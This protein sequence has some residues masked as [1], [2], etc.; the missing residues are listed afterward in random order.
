MNLD[1][2][3]D[4]FDTH[5]GRVKFFIEQSAVL[6]ISCFSPPGNGEESKFP[7]ITFLYAMTKVR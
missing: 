7:F 4:H 5:E 3:D 6:A 1:D 2:H